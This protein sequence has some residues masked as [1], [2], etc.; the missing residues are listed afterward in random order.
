MTKEFTDFSDLVASIRSRLACADEAREDVEP[1]NESDAP[2]RR[3]AVALVLR[4]NLSGAEMLVI[5]RSV[6]ERDHWSGHLALPGG[7]VEG[8][9]ASLLAAAV[10]ETFEEVGVNLEAGGEVLGRL[11]VVEPKSPLAPRVSVAPFVAVAPAEYHVR[12]EEEVTPPLVLSE[13]VAAAFWVPVSKLR[14]GGR[15]DVFKMAFAGV[16]R[17]WP[18]YPS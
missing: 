7:R 13:E 3:A 1:S 16:E 2:L 5:K 12:R 17:E 18:A 14:E 4:R 15:S 11:G 10:R 9:D 6:S 8:G